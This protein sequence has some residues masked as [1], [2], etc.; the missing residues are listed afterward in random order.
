[1]KIT[2][3]KYIAALKTWI[4]IAKRPESER[5]QMD[6]A[7]GALRWNFGRGAAHEPKVFCEYMDKHPQDA[8]RDRNRSLPPTRG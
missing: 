4:H 7:C 3:D 2:I 8:R 5:A 6:K 1:M